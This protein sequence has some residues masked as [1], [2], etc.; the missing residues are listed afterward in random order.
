[1]REYGL[2]VYEFYHRLQCFRENTTFYDI[3]AYDV[4]IP[5]LKI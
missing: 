3:I 1:M 4:S 5:V 2:S